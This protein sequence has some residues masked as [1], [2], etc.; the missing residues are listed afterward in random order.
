LS[1]DH[2]LGNMIKGSRCVND[3]DHDSTVG[4]VLIAMELFVFVGCRL[5]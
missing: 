5:S 4:M 3:A 2:S 1:F